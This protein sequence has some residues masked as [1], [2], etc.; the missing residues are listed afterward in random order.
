VLNLAQ[1]VDTRFL[2]LLYNIIKNFEIWLVFMFIC[3]CGSALKVLVQFAAVDFAQ[4]G[5]EGNY[6]AP[7]GGD[8]GVMAPRPNA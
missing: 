6:A 8:Y 2:I 3:M 5:D 1:L 4:G 7:L